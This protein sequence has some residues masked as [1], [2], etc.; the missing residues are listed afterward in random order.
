M[1]TRRL[2]WYLVFGVIWWGM[3]AYAVITQLQSSMSSWLIIFIVVC[4][5]GWAVHA[6]RTRRRERSEIAQLDDWYR[7]LEA[8]VDVRDFDDDGQFHEYF[9][10]ADRERLIQELERMPRGSR[11]LRRAVK[12]VNPELVDDDA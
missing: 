9:E 4:A 11:S 1:A 7:R 8:V 3:V 10:P 2:N 6:F 5:V 12:I